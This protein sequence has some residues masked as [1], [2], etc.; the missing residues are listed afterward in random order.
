MCKCAYCLNILIEILNQF[1]II[2]PTRIFNNGLLLFQVTGH[3]KECAIYSF[4]WFSEEY[5][6]NN[7]N[8]ILL[9]IF[10]CVD[11]ILMQC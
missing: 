11:N 3:S 4:M 5:L 8:I 7:Y 1:E 9:S 10:L 2:Q 6:K